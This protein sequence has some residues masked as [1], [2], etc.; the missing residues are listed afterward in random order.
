MP[1]RQLSSS[2][3]GEQLAAP[4]CRQDRSPPSA[5]SHQDSSLGSQR[6]PAS[7]PLRLPLLLYR[8]AGQHG[9]RTSLRVSSQCSSDELAAGVIPPTRRSSSIDHTVDVVA[10]ISQA[11]T[12]KHRVLKALAKLLI[13][14]ASVDHA[15]LIQS[16]AVKRW[17]QCWWNWNECH[18]GKMHGKAFQE[19][20]DQQGRP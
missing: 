4:Y 6:R 8:K 1:R 7:G 3:A 10:G 13:E 11:L 14:Q 15:A 18:V 12:A 2:T 9:H 20:V 19:L 17:A 5:A 16:M